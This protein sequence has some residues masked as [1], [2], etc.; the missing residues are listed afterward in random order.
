MKAERKENKE[1]DKMQF[2]RRYVRSEDFD[3][4]NFKV[5]LIIVGRSLEEIQTGSRA[6]LPKNC[7]VAG[8]RSTDVDVENQGL[9]SEELINVAGRAKVGG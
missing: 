4:L 8:I 3:E 6:S 7:W 9:R 1:C 2:E 5:R